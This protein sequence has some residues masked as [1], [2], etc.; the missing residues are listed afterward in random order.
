MTSAMKA[1]C[2]KGDEKKAMRADSTKLKATVFLIF[3]S[4][5]TIAHMKFVARLALRRGQIQGFHVSNIKDSLPLV[6]TIKCGRFCIGK[7]SSAS[8]S[9]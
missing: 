4:N 2:E 8:F 1:C 3:L 6:K 7:I 5:R 9:Q